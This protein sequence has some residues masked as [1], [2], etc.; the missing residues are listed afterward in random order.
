MP[1]KKT[2]LGEGKKKGRSSGGM[3]IRPANVER[4]GDRFDHTAYLDEDVVV[5][6]HS[7]SDSPIATITGNR[8]KA[9]H[10]ILDCIDTES[11][12][13]RKEQSEKKQKYRK[14][15][16]LELDDVKNEPTFRGDSPILQACD[17]GGASL[18]RER[19]QLLLVRRDDEEDG[20]AVDDLLALWT[21]VPRGQRRS[22][23]DI[24]RFT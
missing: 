5:E 22:R 4:S 24:W 21:N 9:D 15:Q 18:Q 11:Q 2:A 16:I 14:P 10:Y 20:D 1:R 17:T 3:L 19:D 12:D 6:Y 8:S 7:R 13:P 23:S